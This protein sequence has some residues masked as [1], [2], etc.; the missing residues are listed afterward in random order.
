MS[1]FRKYSAHELREIR[2]KYRREEIEISVSQIYQQVLMSARHNRS[3]FVEAHEHPQPH[4]GS[5]QYI[6]TS[7]EKVEVLKDLFPGTSVEYC[8]QWIEDKRDPNVKRLKQGFKIDW[9]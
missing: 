8:E 6:P 3:C 2:E 5:N 7:A 9:S 1:R 4:P